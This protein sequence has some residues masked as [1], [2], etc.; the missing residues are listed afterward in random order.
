MFPKEELAEVVNDI[1]ESIVK[2]GM[3]KD[4]NPTVCNNLILVSMDLEKAAS[5]VKQAKDLNRLPSIRDEAKMFLN[6]MDTISHWA[7]Y[8]AWKDICADVDDIG[9][10]ILRMTLEI[11]GSLKP[12]PK[13]KKKKTK[14]GDSVTPLTPHE[15]ANIEDERI[16]NELRAEKEALR[17][18]IAENKKINTDLG[19][20]EDTRVKTDDPLLRTLF[21]K[22]RG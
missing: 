4:H 1:Q 6:M 3:N 7:K 2:I 15:L 9:D 17:V 12:E 10:D 5:L 22:M 13:N 20:F 18:K 11:Q 21:R 14:K 8:K 19:A 16:W